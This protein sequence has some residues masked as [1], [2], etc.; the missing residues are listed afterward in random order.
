MKKLFSKTS[1]YFMSKGLDILLKNDDEV[2]DRLAIID[3]GT[4]IKLSIF[5]Q[6][7]NL[8]LVKMNDGFV[9]T[10]IN[11][12]DLEITFKFFA[13]LPKIVFGKSSVTDC[14]LS[15]EFFVIGELRYAVAIV[16]AIEKFMAYIMPKKRYQKVYGR[17]PKNSLSKGK[18]F[19]KL[20]FARRRTE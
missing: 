1:F 8:I 4:S 16:F 6:K 5:G 12:V 19:A 2:K 7:E 20:L 18:M 13:S 14:Y 17:P 3:D 15:D 11:D 10:K 9:V